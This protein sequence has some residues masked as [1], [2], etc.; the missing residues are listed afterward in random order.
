MALFEKYSTKSTIEKLPTLKLSL[1]LKMICF[2]RT[3]N[4][5][6]SSLHPYSCIRLKVSSNPIHIHM[7]SLII[8][9]MTHGYFSILKYVG[10]IFRLM[11]YKFEYNFGQ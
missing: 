6:K 8:G 1:S 2:G 9:F 10:G 7:N 11:G 5:C 4:S 3:K